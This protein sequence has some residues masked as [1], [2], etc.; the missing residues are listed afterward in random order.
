MIIAWHLYLSQM[1]VVSSSDFLPVSFAT[2]QANIHRLGPILS[3]F[4]SEVA[5][6]KTWSLFWLLVAIGSGYFVQR[7]RDARSLVFFIAVLGPIGIYAF[8]Y[9]FSNWQ[10]YLKH[11][12]LSVSRLLMHVAPLS[13]LTVSVALAARWPQPARSPH[14]NPATCESADRERTPDVEF[15]RT[16]RA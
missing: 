7:Y 4:F 16:K 6:T 2:F 10:D 14:L 1:H 8:I 11:V 13:C 3:A 5:D 15:A 9:I 12:D